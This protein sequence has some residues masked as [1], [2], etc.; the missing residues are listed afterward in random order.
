MKKTK[1]KKGFS[2][3]EVILAIAIFAMFATAVLSLSVDTARRDIINTHR[4]NASLYVQEGL[5]AV[6]QMKSIDFDLI[7]N[8]TYGLELENGAW[9]LTA[10]INPINNTYYRSLNI[11]DV[12]RDNDGNIVDGGLNLD[13]NLKKVVVK[14]EWNDN[15]T[16]YKDKEIVTY[17]SNWRSTDFTINSC[18]GFNAG[19]YISAEVITATNPADCILRSLSNAVESATNFTFNLGA[20]ANDLDYTTTGYLYVGLSAAPTVMVLDV[21]NPLIPVLMDSIGDNQTNGLVSDGFYIYAGTDERDNTLT[22]FDANDVNDLQLASETA[23]DDEATKPLFDNNNVY[24]GIKNGDLEIHSVSDP[25]NPSLRSTTENLGNSVNILHKSG[26]YLFVGA[27]DDPG[28]P[29]FFIYDVI[30]PN[31]PFMITSMDISNNIT[32]MAPSGSLLYLG[33]DNPAGTLSIMDVSDVWT[34]SLE[35]S[36]NVGAT[37]TDVEVAYGYLYIATDD[38]VDAVKVYNLNNPLAPS[39][40]YEF[41]VGDGANALVHDGA[42]LYIAKKDN[43]GL[44]IKGL[45]ESTFTLTSEYE[46]AVHDTGSDLTDYNYLEFDAN[47][48]AGATLDFQIRTA[49]TAANLLLADWVGPDGTDQTFYDTNRTEVTLSPTATGQRFVQIKAYLTSDSVNSAEIDSINLNYVP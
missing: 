22:I 5:E 35:A 43:D 9:S 28:F 15:L 3:I 16:G 25:E 11:S 13:P 12:Y 37:I 30:S 46:S 1:E 33:T 18:D 14:V 23:T 8:G 21:S 34:P 2:L 32:S 20:P 26:Q 44:Y 47:V 31:W 4:S 38:L 7:N 45:T 48:P 39:L 29:Q 49:D 42:Y 41:S 27:S 36:F 40:E 17:V 19:T 6:K 24:V 10:E